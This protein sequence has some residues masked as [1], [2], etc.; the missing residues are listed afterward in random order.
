MCP[1][2]PCCIA[3]LCELGVAHVPDP[4]HTTVSV[5]YPQSRSSLR[6]L[7]FA[8]T[9]GLIS[10]L[11]ERFQAKSCGAEAPLLLL[12]APACI[13]HCLGC[14]MAMAVSFKDTRGANL[15]SALAGADAL[16]TSECA[17][18][19]ASHASCHE[20]SQL[21]SE[22]SPT[23]LHGPQR[24]LRTY[25][26]RQRRETLD[27]SPRQFRGLSITTSTSGCASWGLCR[28]ACPCMCSRLH[29]MG[30]RSS[31]LPSPMHSHAC[32]LLNRRT[33]LCER[34]CTGPRSWGM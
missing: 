16:D 3:A 1:P 9:R 22:V 4:Q 13:R 15:V 7:G 21:F 25:L 2:S 10:S 5:F 28:H 27:G 20:V 30:A 31:R 32:L 11:R 33:A 34:P 29:F 12:G 19:T 26:R 23:P 14:I 8:D 17:V 6:S 18:A 24:F